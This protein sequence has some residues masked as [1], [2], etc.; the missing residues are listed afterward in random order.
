M[1]TI[2]TSPLKLPAHPAAK[3]AGDGYHLLR[4]AAD[5][6]GCA[7]A[8]LADHQWPEVE[9]RARES[10]ALE[11][12][13]LNAEEAGAIQ[14]PEARVEQALATLRARYADQREFLDE[15]ARN[16][17]D[18]DSLRHALRREL[19]FDAVM[20]S[21]GARH[22]PITAKEERAFYAQYA[23]RFQRPETRDARHLLITIN[24][25]FAENSRAA[26][27]ARIEALAS[28]LRPGDAAGFGALARQ[29][30]ECPTALQDGRL[31]TLKAGQLY[32]ELDAV[33]FTLSMGAISGVLE[34]PL[35]FHLLYCERIVPAHAL[36]FEQA[37]ARIHQALR[38]RHQRETQ[39]A[40]IARL[41][42]CP[43]ARASAA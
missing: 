41:R 28:E 17:L 40:W 26:A 21:V 36:S 34:S 42:A 39:R 22:E 4:A 32:P 8:G 23:P 2:L 31:G 43:A 6:F 13:V 35:G 29:H 30:S 14:I 27:R 10:H 18:L 12:L 1:N 7:L 11:T 15:L 16:G 19:L 38:E 37:R 9:A 3:P 5:L 24:A 33:L 25:E 20:R